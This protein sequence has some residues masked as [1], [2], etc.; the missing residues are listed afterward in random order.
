[1]PRKSRVN[2]EIRISPVRL[3]DENDNQIGVV[4]LQEAFRR[5]E[6]AGLDLV[7]VAANSRPPVCRIM[8]YGKH[9]Y[10]ESKKEQRARAKAK[11]AEMKEVRL[12]RTIKVDQHDVDIRVRKA[13]KFLLGGHKVQISQQFR[14]REMQHRDLGREILQKVIDQLSDVSKLDGPIRQAGR[15]MS[16]VVSPD[17][18]KIRTY[19][20]K[21]QAEADAKAKEEAEA[22]EAA[23]AA[24]E[25][26]TDE[27]D[28]AQDERD[29]E[30]EAAEQQRS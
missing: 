3:I 22:A 16:V 1:M 10:E 6:E 26:P 23:E 24:E 11:S 29:A 15:T 4:D 9:R 8:D 28:E 13:R 20:R 19:E 2:R 27:P 21:M 12:G 30:T 7:E 5:A 18:D 14:G 25:N 17:K